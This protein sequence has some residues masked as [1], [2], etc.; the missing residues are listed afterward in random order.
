VPLSK[1]QIDKLGERLKTQEPTEAELRELEEYRRSFVAPHQH[2]VGTI[3]RNLEVEPT[4]RVPKTVA[5]IISKLRRESIRLS[6]IQDIAGCRIITDTRES[7]DRIVDQL[8]GAFTEVSIV[9]RRNKP[10]Y[11]Y[12][13]VHAIVRIADRS[14]EIQVR[15]VLQHQWAELSEEFSERMPGLKYGRDEG[16]IGT[17]LTSVSDSLASLEEKDIQIAE[18][19]DRLEELPD[20]S[21]RQQVAEHLEKARII[22]EELRERLTQVLAGLASIAK[23]LEGQD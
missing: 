12:R 18:I 2:V 10:S 13:A 4:G 16:E 11:G 17:L 1:T 7:Q 3:R 6:Q 15:T 5:S 23:E 8:K 20:A 14:V 21:K 9:D 19:R 22:R